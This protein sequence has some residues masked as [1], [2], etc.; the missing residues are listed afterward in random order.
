MG[1]VFHHIMFWVS[2][3]LGVLQ[4][5]ASMYIFRVAPELGWGRGMLLA[6]VF[7]ALAAIHSHAM[8]TGSS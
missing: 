1:P 6:V 3:V 2:I 4:L 5:L 7:F 8:G